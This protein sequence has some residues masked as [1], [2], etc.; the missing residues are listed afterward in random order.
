MDRLLSAALASAALAGCAVV[1]GTGDLQRFEHHVTLTSTAPSMQG[2]TVRLY[3]REIVPAAAGRRPVVLFVHGAGTPAE[4][5]FDSKMDDYSWMRQVAHAG[6]DVFSVSLTGY[7]GSTRPAPMANPCN[8]SKAQQPGYVQA[9]CEP[10]RRLP[11]TTMSSDWDDIGAVVDHLR[12]LRNVDKV[13]LVGWSQGGPRITGYAVRN[14]SKVE[15]IVVLAP[16]Y[17][18]GGMAEAP[19]ALPAMNDGVMTVQSRKD[20]IAN[21]DRQVGCPAQYDGAAASRIFD[22][23]LQSDPVGAAWG[24]GAR[25]APMVPTWGFDRAAVAKV[26]A[27]YLM[28][29]GEHDKQVAPQRVRELYEDL[30]SADK[31]LVEMACSSHN[32]MWEMHRAKL[33]DATVQWL[34]DGRLNGNRNGVVRIG[35]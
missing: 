31:V 10:D 19:A 34:R 25:R 27:P 24:P 33:Y 32:A 7:G 2:Q 15:R 28:V 17:N 23:M 11:L 26:T 3:V 20:F 13:S 9:P 6:F 29:A 22:E 14:P 12:G 5:S 16:A 1:P 18:R 4:V 35:Y 30:G 21:W 8:L